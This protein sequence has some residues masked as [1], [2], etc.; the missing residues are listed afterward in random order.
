MNLMLGVGYDQ[1]FTYSYSLRELTYAGLSFKDDVEE[2]VK[3]KRYLS[4]YFYGMSISLNLFCN[5]QS[6]FSVFFC[7]TI[8][9]CSGLGL[10]SGAAAVRGKRVREHEEEKEVVSFR[11]LQLLV[12]LNRVLTAK[13]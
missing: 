9:S 12:L 8:T 3:S 7:F 5:S 6:L 11:K 4:G 13:L 2:T 10:G 1:A